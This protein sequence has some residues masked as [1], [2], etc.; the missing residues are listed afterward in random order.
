MTA[1]PI[2]FRRHHPLDVVDAAH[3]SAVERDDQV[4]RAQPPKRRGAALDDLDH[5]DGRPRPSRAASRGGTGR[6]PPAMPM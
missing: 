6:E 5:L 1:S 4:L 2:R 3:L